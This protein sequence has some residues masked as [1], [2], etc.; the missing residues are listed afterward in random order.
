M[1]PDNFLGVH[2]SNISVY[3]TLDELI[4][5]PTISKI[6]NNDFQQ[7]KFK[8]I[9]PTPLSLPEQAEVSSDK[10][11]LVNSNELWKL[12]YANL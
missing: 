8:V 3:P 6:D 5:E 11:D 2:T 12:T 7:F 10:N 9:Q 4:F 1:K